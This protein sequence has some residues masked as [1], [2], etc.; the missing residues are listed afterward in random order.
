MTSATPS[1]NSAE[2]TSLRQIDPDSEP[3]NGNPNEDDYAEASVTPQVVDISVNGTVNDPEPSK[4]DTIQ[5]VFTVLNSGSADASNLS[6]RSLVP[7][8]LTL[9]SSQPQLGTSYDSLT[10][11]WDVGNLASGA[12]GQLVLNVR[13]DERG[14]KRVPIEVISHDEFDLDST[15]GNGILLED[16]Q[17]EVLIRAP[18][19]LVTRLFLSR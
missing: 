12:T 11:Q 2:V 18:R 13:V 16:D 8:G 6:L 7:A 4:G 5:I 3:G 10:G 15:P 19:R 9:I 14:V 1:S 17:T